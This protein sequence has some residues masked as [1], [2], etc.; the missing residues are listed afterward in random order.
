M[1]ES[2]FQLHLSTEQCQQYYCGEVSQVQVVDDHN[3]RIQFPA[4]MLRK[5]VS[6][7]G[8]DGEFILKYDQDNR[9]VSLERV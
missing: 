7:D 5:H 1:P 8:V 2:R 3:R 4:A 9:L 6:H